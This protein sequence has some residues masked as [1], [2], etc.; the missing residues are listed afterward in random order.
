[1][2]IRDR[3]PTVTD[4]QIAKAET[5]ILDFTGNLY[6]QHIGLE[7]ID[8][9]RPEEHFSDLDSLRAAIARDIS[10]AAHVPL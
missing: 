10:Y 6:D 4:A 9:I 2:C 3:R 1:M 5:Y 7:L 8:F